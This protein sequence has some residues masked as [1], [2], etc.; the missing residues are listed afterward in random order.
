MVIAIIG[1]LSSVVLASLSGARN[2]A[3]IAAGKQFEHNIRSSVSHCSEAFYNF[4]GDSSTIVREASGYSGRDGTIQGNP[5]RVDSLNGLG[6][7]MEF[8]G[9]IDNLRIYSCAL[10]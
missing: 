10:N 1:I 3:R 9:L 6:Q 4:E 5:V 7:A 8:D 2:S